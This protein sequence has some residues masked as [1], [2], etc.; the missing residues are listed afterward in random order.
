MTRGHPRSTRSATLFPY[1]TLFRS[2]ERRLQGL[3]ALR[4]DRHGARA[5]DAPDPEMLEGMCAQ[6]GADAPGEV[7]AA[8]APVQ[9]RKAEHARRPPGVEAHRRIAPE[10]VEER[11][12]AVGAGSG[13]TPERRRG[14]KRWGAT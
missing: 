3:P 7:R 9:A 10:P 5:V 14:G 11:R 13:T 12:A 4:G 6:G 2:P 1:A 8:L